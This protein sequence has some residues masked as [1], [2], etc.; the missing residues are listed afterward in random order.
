MKRVLW[1]AALAAAVL[2]TPFES[3]DAAKLLPVQ[4]L[5]MYGQDGLCVLKTDNGLYGTG[6]DP[7]EAVADLENTAPGT[8]V[9]STARQLVI[10]DCGARYLHPLLALEVLHP[11]IAL[12]AADGP[13]DPADAAAFLD[14]SGPGLSVS[15]YQASVLA[16][17]DVVLPRLTGGEGRYSIL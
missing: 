16:G 11:G 12:Y 6:T 13:V 4:T 1:I 10:A 15:R 7:A 3:R 14:R 9:L 5:C 2:F 8:V 17:E